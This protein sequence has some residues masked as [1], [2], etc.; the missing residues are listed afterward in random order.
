MRNV[1]RISLISIFLGIYLPFLFRFYSLPGFRHDSYL[2]IKVYQRFKL[3]KQRTK[4]LRGPIELN[5]EYNQHA[6]LILI[7]LRIF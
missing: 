1:L 5:C 2:M 6:I 3:F 7:P 4:S